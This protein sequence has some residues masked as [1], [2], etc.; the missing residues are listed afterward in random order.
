[1]RFDSSRRRL[2][3]ALPFCAT[4]RQCANKQLSYTKLPISIPRQ[5]LLGLWRRYRN[6]SGRNR[7]FLT[8]SSN[9]R[10]VVFA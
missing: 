9:L 2:R 3:S 7:P 1:M 8:T 4:T 6:I 10:R 5:H